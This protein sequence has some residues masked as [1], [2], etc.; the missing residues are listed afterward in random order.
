[1]RKV[2]KQTTEE[3]LVVQSTMSREFL[4]KVTPAQLIWKFLVF[5]GI[6]RFFAVFMEVKSE[7]RCKISK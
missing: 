5:W 6:G 2:R 7:V 4:L 3:A 1:M